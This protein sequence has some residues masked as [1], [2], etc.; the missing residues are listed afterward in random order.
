[1]TGRWR[2][3]ALPADVPV[4][5]MAAAR[6]LQV[7]QRV[8][9]FGELANRPAT[10]EEL[11]H[12]LALRPH[13]TRL[14][15]DTLCANAI[16]RRGRRDRYV[17]PRRSARWLDPTSATYVVAFVTDTHHQSSWWAELET[18]VCRRTSAPNRDRDRDR[19][20]DDP[21]WLMYVL[22]QYQLARLSSA[23]V[24]AAVP[25]AADARSV[26]DVAGGHGEHSMALGRRHPELEATVVDLPGAAAVGQGIVE[27]AGFAGR[28]RFVEGDMFAVDLGGPYDAALCC[29]VVHH[30][31][32][33]ETTKL[34]GRIASALPE[35]APLCIVDRFNDDG[36]LNLFTH[37]ASGTGPHTRDD[38]ANWVTASG[39][40]VSRIRRVARQLTLLVASRG[41]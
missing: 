14:L 23:A 26:L 4:L 40:H 39:F 2:R 17:L 35:R 9:I 20:P 10:A 3:R 25:L 12:Q 41:S 1:M 15:L 36:P 31:D 38:V 19:A 16:V 27:R 28:V 6:S 37:L 30:L 32:P 33:A 22:G 34:F 5:A 24:A 7:A 21:Y 11:A 29:N 8:G 18:L 13:G